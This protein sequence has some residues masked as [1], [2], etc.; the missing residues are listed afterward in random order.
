MEKWNVYR[1]VEQQVGLIDFF[2]GGN[3]EFR[4]FFADRN[5]NQWELYFDQVWDF[6]YA[7]ENAFI[8]RCCYL[9]KEEAWTEINSIYLVENSE[10]VKY[11]EEQA[12]GTRSIDDLKHFLIFDDMDTGLEILTNKEP[13]LSPSCHKSAST[14]SPESLDARLEGMQLSKLRSFWRRVKKP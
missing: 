3:E 1:K 7:I 10:Y 4:V 2:V 11:F 5:R 13:I 8:D 9:K 14:F 12:S 6:R